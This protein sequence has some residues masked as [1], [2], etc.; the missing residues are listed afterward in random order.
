M[1]V[2][3]YVVVAKD[4]ERATGEVS[5]NT[6]VL[7]ILKKGEMVARSASACCDKVNRELLASTL[8]GTEPDDVEVLVRPFC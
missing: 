1:Q 2:F 8:D 5:Q 6:H 4:P 3:E 7:R